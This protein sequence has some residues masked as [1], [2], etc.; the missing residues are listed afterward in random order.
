MLGLRIGAMTDARAR[1][2]LLSDSP[3]AHPLA[4]LPP[5]RATPASWA[6][7]SPPMIKVHVTAILD[8]EG[9]GLTGSVSPLGYGIGEGTWRAIQ[10]ED[11][12]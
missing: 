12:L 4:P 2:R 5:A 1:S 8:Q 10:K 7:A 11:F 3:G 9:L 6:I